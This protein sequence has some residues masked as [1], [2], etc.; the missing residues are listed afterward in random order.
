MGYHDYQGCQ[1]RVAM[2][3]E[4]KETFCCDVYNEAE[5]RVFVTVTVC[6]LC[7]VCAEV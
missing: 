7:N 2:C 4:V 1:T 5:K 6:V 3:M